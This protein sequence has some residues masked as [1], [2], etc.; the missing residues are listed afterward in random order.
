[1]ELFLRKALREDTE[2]KTL[3][4]T[5]SSGYAKVYSVQA[6]QDITPSYVVITLVSK[7]RRQLGSQNY[8]FQFSVFSDSYGKAKAIADKLVQKIEGL[9]SQS[10]IYA[11]YPENELEMYEEATKL[12]H[13]PIDAIFYRL[14]KAD[15]A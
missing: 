5:D 3:I 12:Y 10:N 11:V 7:P 4:G 9:D 8:R 2:I 13:I 14:E 1:M 15:F 6:L